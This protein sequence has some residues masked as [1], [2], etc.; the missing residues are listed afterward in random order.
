MSGQ[1]ML[2]ALRQDGMDAHCVHHM[3]EEDA[4]YAVAIAKRRE[5]LVRGYAWL[6]A[7]KPSGEQ[8]H[9]AAINHAI[10]ERWSM[11]ALLYIKKK[12]WAVIDGIR[13]ACES[14][15]AG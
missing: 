15:V 11:N 13:S 1:E 5:D 7:S 9:F 3:S 4:A 10:V 8:F 14:E 2:D 12:A 6:I